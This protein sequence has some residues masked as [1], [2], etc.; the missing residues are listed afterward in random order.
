MGHLGLSTIYI[1]GS[2]AWEHYPIVNRWVTMDIN[3][4]TNTEA[5]THMFTLYGGMCVQGLFAAPK[6]ITGQT[7]VSRLQAAWCGDENPVLLS[8]LL[9]G[10]ARA[11]GIFM[12]QSSE[13][14]PNLCWDTKRTTTRWEVL[15]VPRLWV[16]LSQTCK[17]A[18]FNYLLKWQHCVIQT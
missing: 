6:L 17:F 5:C 8:F 18:A 10:R 12:P 3:V 7:K 14:F 2:G 1:C 13:R 11:S 9:V 16:F 4:H 15:E